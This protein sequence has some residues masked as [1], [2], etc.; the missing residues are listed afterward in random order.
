[1]VIYYRRIRSDHGFRED[2]NSTVSNNFG[3]ENGCAGKQFEEEVRVTINHN[4][5]VSYSNIEDVDVVMLIEFIATD[6]REPKINGSNICQ[7]GNKQHLWVDY[8]TLFKRAHVE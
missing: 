7:N 1:M 3:N 6:I 8:P 4:E 5:E 2:T